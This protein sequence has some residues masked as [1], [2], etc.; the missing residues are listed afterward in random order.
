MPK[1]HPC[2]LLLLVVYSLGLFVGL[3]FVYMATQRAFLFTVEWLLLK[4]Y[5]HVVTSIV[6]RNLTESM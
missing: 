4:T 5:E 1:D 3:W 6:A 2:G